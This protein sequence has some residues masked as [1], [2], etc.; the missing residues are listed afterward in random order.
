MIITNLCVDKFDIKFIGWQ[1]QQL[2]KNDNL[3]CWN[4][5]QNVKFRG[6]YKQNLMWTCLFYTLKYMY[7]TYVI[8]NY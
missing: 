2:G 7:G 3:I 5:F 6:T 1:E 4:Y 8:T